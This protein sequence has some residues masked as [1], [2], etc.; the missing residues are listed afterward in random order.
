MNAYGRPAQ[1]ELLALIDRKYTRDLPIQA[2]Y[3][4]KHVNSMISQK[5]IVDW[6]G[7]EG[8][9]DDN[10]WLVSQEDV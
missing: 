6:D 8:A 1:V 10:V 7:V 2:D 5:V 9:T 4:G 3:T